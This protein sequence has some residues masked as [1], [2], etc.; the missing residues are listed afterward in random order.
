MTFA[1]VIAGAEPLEG[2]FA[3]S[4]PASWMQG[5]TAYGGF[6]AALTV[7]AGQAAGGQGVDEVGLPPLRSAQFAMIAPVS[8][9]VAVTAWVVRRGR[10]A[11]WVQA[12]ITAQGHLAFTA[13][14]V[15]MG[16][17][18]SAIHLNDRVAPVDIVDVADALPLT[19]THH[20]P[21]FLRENFAARHARPPAGSRQPEMC[22]WVR[23][24]ERAGI[25]PMVELV[26][27]ADSLPPG[28]MPLL[29]TPVPVST[30]HWQVNLLAP[31]PRTADGWWLL[32]S[33]GDYAEKGCSSQRM[34]I[35]NRAGEPIMAGTQ[36]IAI[37]G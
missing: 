19:I 35:W 33:V 26:L 13:S 11:T 31:L 28:V 32:R 34:A 36:S 3:L 30:M 16:A 7:V 27:V 10:N 12:E 8:G 17:V 21:A 9:M 22:R 5:R 6:S 2:G 23:L 20:T 29:P 4:I 15:F 24:N 25:D 14:L 1:E 37:F 18:D